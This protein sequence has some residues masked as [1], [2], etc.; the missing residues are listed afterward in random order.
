M[1]GQGLHSSWSVSLLRQC[2]LQLDSCYSIK[3][4]QNQ[5]FTI[6]IGAWFRQK[7]PR[8][9]YLGGSNSLFGVDSELLQ[10]KTNLPVVNYSIQAGL[11]LSFYFREVEPQLHQGDH[12]IL[13]LEYSFYGGIS[14]P[15]AVTSILNSYPAGIP[16]LLPDIWLDL[17]DYFKR[18]MQRRIQR[19]STGQQ[20]NSSVFDHTYNRWGDGTYLLDYSGEITLDIENGTIPS[21][22]QI[23]PKVIDQI[24][25]FQIRLQKTG[26]KMWISY[27]SM[28]NRQFDPQVQNAMLLDQYLREQ[29]PGAVIS[30]PD[31]YVFKKIYIS[32]TSYHLNREGRRIRTELLITDIHSAGF[33]P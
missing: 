3:D 13:L 30:T 23:D 1:I 31:E 9:V 15:E 32:N 10:D 12:V 17:P 21:P 14:N 33:L 26:A 8:L 27:P 25:S 28:W 6:N 18:L 29:F 2:S 22:D 11:P 4:I 24:K 5:I 19:I 16:S 7:V 20:N